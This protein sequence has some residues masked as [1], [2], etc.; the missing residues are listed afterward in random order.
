MSPSLSP[1]PLGRTGL[2]VTPMG[3]GTAALG[4]PGYLNLGHASDLP[5]RSVQGMREHAWQLLDAAYEAGIR[6]VDAAR[7]YGRAEEFVAGWLEARRHQDVVVTSKW[8]YTYVADWR[9]DV[10]VHEVKDHTRA[11]LDRQLA[12]TRAALGGRLA[13]YQIHSATLES[14]VLDDE[15]VLAALRDLADDG[16]V[17]GL[18]TSGP[19][20]AQVIRRALALAGRGAA[21]FRTV[22]ATW[23]L[24]E[25]SAG[26]A[27][28]EAAAAGWGVM[29]KEGVA[30]G[31]LT[32]R[33]DAPAQLRGL[34]RRLGLSMDAL[35]LAAAL[36]QPFASVVLSGASTVSQLA[37]NLR[38]LRV[39]LSAD[40]LATALGHAEDPAAYWAHRSSLPWT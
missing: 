32:E 19:A 5:D 7:S 11:T 14:G 36:A 8:G 33:G 34:A 39:D 1:R 4:R 37:D 12:E 29:V 23:N 27:L 18:S 16:V 20:Q 24:L 25:P 26:P 9:T 28:Q 3:L 17:V 6:H 31:R 40:D 15:E 21:P 2:L 38:A 13:A 22:Q 30:N 10:D 35:A